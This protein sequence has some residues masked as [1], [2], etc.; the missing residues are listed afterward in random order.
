MRQVAIPRL[1]RQ[2]SAI[3]FGCA[4]LG[5]RISKPAGHR[6]IDRAIDRGLN[7]FDVAPSYGDGRAEALLGEALRGQRDKVII[8][9]KFGIAPPQVSL[10]ARLLRPMARQAV[11]TFPGLRR[12]VSRA[13]STGIRAAI[14][15]TAI[16]A[17]VSRSLRQLRTD[18]I[19]VLAVHEPSLTD[20]ANA[21]IF[22]VLH[23]LIERGLIRAIS[24]AGNPESIKATIHGGQPL[25]V[26]QFPDTPLTEAV[27]TLRRQ[28]ADAVPKF[29]THGVF[30]SGIMQSLAAMS[31][32]QAA[33][34][35]ALAERHGIDPGSPSDLLLRF[36]F[37]NNPDG[38]VI[39]SMFDIKHIDRNIAVAALPPIAGLAHDVR[40]SLTTGHDLQ[41]V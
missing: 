13:R 3:G 22:G 15:P 10:P 41:T 5:S 14:D 28:L 35:I 8:C 12:T 7:W 16:E 27:V 40:Q 38:V 31:P 11:A 9:T 32:Q 2:V 30:G 26:A 18:Y 34:I 23:R 29:V 17:S 33:G 4:S 21:E 6:A 20:A 37:S 39:I 25:D 36:A 19:D 1:G 24:V